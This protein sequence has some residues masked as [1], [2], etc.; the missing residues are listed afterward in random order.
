MNSTGTEAY[1]SEGKDETTR[2]PYRNLLAIFVPAQI[3][4]KGQPGRGVPPCLARWITARE[5]HHHQAF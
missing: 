3:R 4:R 1:A 5:Q 2:N